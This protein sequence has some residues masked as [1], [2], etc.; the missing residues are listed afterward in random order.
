[1]SLSND[2]A[3]SKL[4]RSRA[5]L[6]AD[7]LGDEALREF[8]ADDEL[9]DPESR[10]SQTVVATLDLLTDV[11]VSRDMSKIE[12][13]LAKSNAID[14]RLT[15][16]SVSAPLAAPLAEQRQAIADTKAHTLNIASLSARLAKAF[17]RISLTDDIATNTE[18]FVL[19]DLIGS[20]KDLVSE[21]AQVVD[22]SPGS[23]TDP[24]LFVARVGSMAEG[25]ERSVELFETFVSGSDSDDLGPIKL[26][27]A[28]HPLH[29]TLH[30][31][32][33]ARGRK[34]SFADDDG[35]DTPADFKSTATAAQSTSW[36]S[37]SV[38]AYAALST[39]LNFALGLSSYLLAYDSYTNAAVL[40]AAES[41]E[42]FLVAGLEV[43]RVYTPADLAN[44]RLVDELLTGYVL[45]VGVSGDTYQRPL[46]TRLGKWLGDRAVQMG[47]RA[48]SGVISATS[49]EQNTALGSVALAIVVLAAIRHRALLIKAAESTFNVFYRAG[50]AIYNAPANAVAKV[51]RLGRSIGDL[52][53][54]EERPA[55]QPIVR[56]R[57][58]R[59]TPLTTTRR[60]IVKMEPAPLLTPTRS[61]DRRDDTGS[62]EGAAVTTRRRRRR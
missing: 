21:S 22:P 47:L 3:E 45:R 36:A 53:V 19:L 41:G 39:V 35:N 28:A 29:S 40:A 31:L 24:G 7:D 27:S 57:P 46:I 58:R 44:L 18:R 51:R 8:L 42:T 13:A 9:R 59:R 10:V 55:P 23:L 12:L 26:I 2:F 16:D 38:V 56:T 30:I 1:M 50:N 17:E 34:R 54:G 15:F 20:L 49:G 60:Q 32:S 6:S 11:D 61:P 52:L 25:F 43:G 4:L 5:E 14:G 48:V 62:G 33:E 37:V